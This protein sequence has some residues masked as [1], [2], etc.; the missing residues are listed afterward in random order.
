VS[1][2]FVSRLWNC[3]S[4]SSSI[5]ATTVIALIKMTSAAS[6]GGGANGVITLESTVNSVSI[7]QATTLRLSSVRLL[8]YGSVTTVARI[9]PR[10]RTGNTAGKMKKRAMATAKKATQIV[11]AAEESRLR[12]TCQSARTISRPKQKVGVAEMLTILEAVATPAM[13]WSTAM[14]KATGS[15]HSRNCRTCASC[16]R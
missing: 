9:G 15:I 11:I 12:D 6:C 2:R 10:I 5:G 8:T 7:S 1:E 14:L 16:C 4:S 13:N 3:H